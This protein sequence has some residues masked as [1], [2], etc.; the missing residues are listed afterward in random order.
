MITSISVG[1]SLKCVITGMSFYSKLFIHKY[2]L[3]AV[4]GFVARSILGAEGLRG[5]ALMARKRISRL[6]VWRKKRI[7][8]SIYLYAVTSSKFNFRL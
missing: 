3:H 7:K 6:F 5:S 1:L 4:A 8:N 2:L